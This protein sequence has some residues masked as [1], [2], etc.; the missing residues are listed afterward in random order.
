MELT[1]GL[2]YMNKKSN[3]YENFD[4]PLYIFRKIMYNYD[5]WDKTMLN[6]GDKERSP[7]KQEN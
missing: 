1:A 6:S 2:C 3:I 7:Q 4:K 5:V